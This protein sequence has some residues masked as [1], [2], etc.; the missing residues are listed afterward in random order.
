[1]GDYQSM[2][3]NIICASVMILPM[4]PSKMD[5]GFIKFVQDGFQNNS[6]R[7]QVQSFDNLPRP[8]EQLS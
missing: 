7:A 4:E 8:T 6:Q 3:W 1:M 5:F 2:K